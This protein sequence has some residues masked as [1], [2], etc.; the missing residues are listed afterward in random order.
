MAT[1]YKR[2]KS[3]DLAAEMYTNRLTYYSYPRD[4]GVALCSFGWNVEDIRRMVASKR[5]CYWLYYAEEE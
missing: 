2:I 3:P 5:P 1:K 4:T